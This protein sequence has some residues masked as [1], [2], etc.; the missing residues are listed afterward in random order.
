MCATLSAAMVVGPDA[1]AVEA[2]ARRLEPDALDERGT[3]DGDEHE[4][5]VDRLPLAEVDGE[6]AAVVVDLRALLGEVQR[7]AALAERL[8]ELLR[9]VL[10][11]CGISVGSISMIVTSVPKRLKID[12]N[13]QP[14]IPPP[15]TTSRAAPRSARGAPSSRRSAASRA[16]GSAAGSGTSRWRRSRS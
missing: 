6:M 10:V 14:M 7:D 15:R 12:A 5:A 1:L 8:R 16:P 11:L 9:R 3:P 4:V 2:D 13:S